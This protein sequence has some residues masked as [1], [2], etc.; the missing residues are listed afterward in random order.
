MQEPLPAAAPFNPPA[1]AA[2]TV[3]LPWEIYEALAAV[4]HD[5]GHAIEDQARRAIEEMLIERKR[6]PLFD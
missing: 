5:E 4:A 3:T 2:I 6:R 1:V